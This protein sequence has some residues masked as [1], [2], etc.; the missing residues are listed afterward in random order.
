MG[1]A[2][3]ISATGSAH[4]IARVPVA[5]SA[6]CRN[7]SAPARFL[8]TLGLV[9][10]LLLAGCA[11]G[12]QASPPDALGLRQVAE[13]PLPGSMSR[14]D[15]QS[16]DPTSGRLYLAH[17]GASSVT[18]FD[19]A[20]QRVEATIEGIADVHGVLAVP[21]VGRVFATATGDNQLAVIDTRTLQV[22]A[23][24]ES[25]RYPDGLAYDPDDGAIFVSDELGGTVSVIDAS[26][27]LRTATIDLGGEVGNTQYDP[28]GKRIY[29]AGQGRNELVAID[30]AVAQVAGRYGLPGCQQPHGLALDAAN[31]LAF[32]AC[33]GNAMLLTVDLR[34]MRVTGQQAVGKQPDVL[35][36]DEGLHR[37]YVAAESGIVTILEERGT[38]IATV[39]QGLLDPSAHS[40]ALDPQT[41]RVYFPLENSHGHPVLRVYE[42]V[43][44]PPSRSAWLLA[45][46]AVEASP[47]AGTVRVAPG[48][49][50]WKRANGSLARRVSRVTSNS[51]H[52][53]T[54]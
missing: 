7:A 44:S 45:A 5:A 27:N 21:Q 14:W 19:I 51:N 3:R 52:W 9:A 50:S 29:S 35:A 43:T 20:S 40:V 11:R 33:E 8:A 32:V 24:V 4:A 2:E 31:R 23:R 49:D 15:Y 16:L 13:I 18:V 36:F 25:G 6:G 38:T 39:A 10:A 17:L 22:V 54:Y 28:I 12:Q 47:R 48:A 34:T 37:L 46:R 42:P 30:P 41:H 53:P 26:T 1:T